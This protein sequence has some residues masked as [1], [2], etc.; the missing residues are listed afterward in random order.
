LV[1]RIAGKV[2]LHIQQLDVQVKTKTKDNV[3]VKIV[4]SVQYYASPDI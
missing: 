4:V 2:N 3:F 1:D